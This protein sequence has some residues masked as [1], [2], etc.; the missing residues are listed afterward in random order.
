MQNEYFGKKIK[1]IWNIIIYLLNCRKKI[2]IRVFGSVIP[3]KIP[4]I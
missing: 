4:I 2:Y 1:E 3:K